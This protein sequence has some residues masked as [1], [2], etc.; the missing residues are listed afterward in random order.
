MSEA[1]SAKTASAFGSAKDAMRRNNFDIVRLLLAVIVV[2]VHADDLAGAPALTPMAHLLN[3]RL[4]VECF[5]VISGFLIFASYER[6]ATLK[7]YFT[8]RALRI[9]PGYWLATLLCLAVAFCGGHFHVGRFL[10]ANLAFANF[11]A[12]S[13]PGVFRHNPFGPEMDGALWTI[14]IEVMFYLVVPVIGWLCRRLNRDL[15]LVALLLLSIVY[16]ALM[17]GHPSLDIQLPGQLSFFMG[18]T[19]IYYHLAAFKRFGWSLC[20]GA[21]LLYAAYAWTGW[22]E[23]RPIPVAILVL[24]ICLLLPQVKGPTRWGDFSYG[25]YVLHWPILQLVISTGAFAVRPWLALSGSIVLIGICAV[26]SWN[27]IEKPALVHA[28]SRQL[29]EA[30]AGKAEN[31]PA[32]VP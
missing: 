27:F 3:A 8:N 1:V 25:T 21:L 17:V 4:G 20:G 29:R 14:K 24:A 13:I 12:P 23:L 5:F 18:G 31:Y 32:A 16:R 9:L 28:K 7:V 6:C 2:L 10:L 30:A 11:L 22:Y 19:L 26:L 15:V